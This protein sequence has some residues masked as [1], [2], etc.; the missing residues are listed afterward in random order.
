M[1]TQ[2][3][4]R[5]FAVASA[6][7]ALCLALAGL[8]GYLLIG[9]LAANL[10][11]QHT[12]TSNPALPTS[13]P[14]TWLGLF[15]LAFIGF[16]LAVVASVAYGLYRVT[17]L[18]ICHDVGSLVRMFGDVREGSLRERYPMALHEFQEI[19]F[20]LRESGERLMRE[21]SR[22]KKLGFIDHLS[23]LSNRRHFERRL[24]EL[25]EA[26]RAKGP[27]SVLLIDIDYF[28]SVND[29]HGHDAG[30]ALIVAFSKALR[31]CVRHSDFLARLGGD[32][33]CVVYPYTSVDKAAAYVERLRKQLPRDVPLL[34][35]LMHPLRWTG[36]LSA[37][38]DADTKF[39]DVLWRADKAL[40]QA[41][42]GGRNNTQI[43]HPRTGL[44]QHRVVLA[45]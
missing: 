28:K 36:G 39:D 45:N 9:D 16:A 35:D 15:Y 23:Q 26:S 21:K 17:S 3:L 12:T 18:A 30:D 33:F 40:I 37:I 22:L 13:L 20:F 7:A 43:F 27:S 31:A 25:F 2:S 6:T 10:A 8:A 14:L 4:R 42:E 38:A 44:E 41:K 29:R 34:R 32:E 11:L 1:R 24:G 5:I 19:F